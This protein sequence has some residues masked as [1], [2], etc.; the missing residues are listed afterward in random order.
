MSFSKT[1]AW[2]ASALLR[3]SLETQCLKELLATLISFISLLSHFTVLLLPLY[4]VVSTGDRE[5]GRLEQQNSMCHLTSVHSYKG[6][7]HVLLTGGQF[8]SDPW[9]A[10]VERPEEA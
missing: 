5:T 7:S 1:Q 6:A 2:E 9:S 4:T 8:P 10:V 3:G